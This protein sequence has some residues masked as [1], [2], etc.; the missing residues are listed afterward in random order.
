MK[1]L[2]CFVFFL[3]SSFTFTQSGKMGGFDFKI[4]NK[5]LTPAPT[6]Q[7]KWLVLCIIII[8][9]TII[10]SDLVRVS[11]LVSFLKFT[12]CGWVNITI[13]RD[14]LLYYVLGTRWVTVTT[15]ERTTFISVIM[16]SGE[17]D[18]VFDVDKNGNGNGPWWK[19]T[20][21]SWGSVMHCAD[22]HH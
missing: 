10:Y 6:Y 15:S 12:L 19:N 4:T 20:D 13:T 22:W 16:C 7:N 14:I 18:Q 8:M 17:E 3:I 5:T 9:I 21:N 1:I 2:W 11:T